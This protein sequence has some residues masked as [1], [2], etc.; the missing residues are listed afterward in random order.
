MAVYTS[1]CK[2]HLGTI[3]NVSD[4]K[5]DF[6]SLDGKTVALRPH[7][8][9]YL[10]YYPIDQLPLK[11]IQPSS[12]PSL[13]INTEV[14]GEIVPLTQGWPIG[15]SK[16]KIA[17]L[18]FSGQDVL[19]ARTSIHQIKEAPLKKP[20]HISKIHKQKVYF[21]PPYI[22]S[23]CEQA[24]KKSIK[25]FP[26]QIL[27]DAIMIKRE[28]DFLKAGY[29]K[30]NRYKREQNFYPNPEVHKN[31]TSL[32]LWYSTGS[33][34][35]SSTRRTNN[36]TPLLT[37][38]YSSDVFDYQHIFQTGSGPMLFGP[39]EE[40]QTQAYYHFKASYFHFSA[41]A[42]PSLVLVGERYKWDKAD[43]TSSDSRVNPTA[44][45]EMGFDFGRWTLDFYLVDSWQV[46]ILANSQFVARDLPISRYGFSYHSN[47]YKISISSGTGSDE[48]SIAEGEKISGGLSR[49]NFESKHFD[50]LILTY[51][52]IQRDLSYDSK[53][54]NF[55][56]QSLTNAF[57]LTYQ[58]NRKYQ[59]GGYT[60][61]EIYNQEYSGISE[62]ETYLK[63]GAFISLSF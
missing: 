59:A 36:F 27:S 28:I 48:I 63:A 42:D 58:I 61:A 29:D 15:F 26:Q 12:V 3:I 8:V 6:L 38:S 39:H 16:D 32:G 1:A 10:S 2:R 49:L 44:M 13:K 40:P 56:S 45:I 19:V 60:A 50:D 57:Y 7:Q 52:L 11:S 23:H 35:G 22:F 14:D 30:V 18:K 33:R 41:M 34:Y 62:S 53:T 31:E 21:V 51:S 9:I 55:K 25:I 17:F 43:F 24:P 20:I 47:L 37:D 54:L 5:I 46:G 4:Q